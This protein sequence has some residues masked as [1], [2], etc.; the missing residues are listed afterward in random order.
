MT[1]W[2]IAF[3]AALTRGAVAVPILNDFKPENVHALVN[4]S[5][6][7]LLFAGCAVWKNLDAAEMPGLEG[8]I[9]L[10]DFSVVRGGEALRSAR[11]RL[12]ALF[13]GDERL[14]H[15][16]YSHET[17]DAR[18]RFAA[19]TRKR[20]GR[21]AFVQPA[22]ASRGVAP[23]AP[24]IAA[25]RHRNLARASGHRWPYRVQGTC[26]SAPLPPGRRRQRGDSDFD[27]ETGHGRPAAPGYR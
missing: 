20:R 9:S 2:W 14:G 6:A 11:A 7:R 24:P 10:E 15:G 12:H 1:N 27:V 19:K 26:T 21:H 13:G 5:E 17:G 18:S 22:A 16:R 8:V 3:F 23:Q 25:G 4:H